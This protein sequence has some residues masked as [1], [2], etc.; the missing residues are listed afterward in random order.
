MI[1][2]LDTNFLAYAEGINDEAR[3]MRAL[4]LIKHLK[5]QDVRLPVQVLGELFRVLTK[6]MSRTTGQARQAVLYWQDLFPVC[7]TTH[8]AFKSA[9]DLAQAHR[10]SIWDA[11][12]LSVAA[13]ND[14][15]IL[16][17][18]DMQDGF[19]WQGVTVVNPFAPSAS[20]F[21]G[22]IP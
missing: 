10:L 8:A 22:Q 20:D 17:S 11:L 12:I 16:L 9:M 21:L 19:V 4:A 15:R 13:H 7:D 1:V 3:K 2:G 18:E 14:C 5:P 6:K